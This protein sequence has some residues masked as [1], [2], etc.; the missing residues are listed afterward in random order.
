MLLLSSWLKLYFFPEKYESTGFK[1]GLVEIGLLE[2]MQEE[3]ICIGEVF[4]IDT[5]SGFGSICIGRGSSSLTYD[6]C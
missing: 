6:S 3:F 4:E 5:E 2:L 1:S